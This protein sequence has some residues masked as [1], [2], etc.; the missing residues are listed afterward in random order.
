MMKFLA[1]VSVMGRLMLRQN[2]SSLGHELGE[3]KPLLFFT[4]RI[5]YTILYGGLSVWVTYV[6]VLVLEAPVL[7]KILS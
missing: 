3:N 5:C 7:K 4:R 1:G 2:F 6:A